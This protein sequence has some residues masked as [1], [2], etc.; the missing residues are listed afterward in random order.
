MGVSDPQ[1]LWSCPLQERRDEAERKKAEAAE[2]KKERQEMEQQEQESLKSGNTGNKVTR[3]QVRTEE[4]VFNK[5]TQSRTSFPD[6]PHSGG[7]Q[8][9]AA[10]V[11]KPTQFGS[12]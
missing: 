2:K 8:T 7:V 6:P 1:R 11:R 10:K 9:S 3:D 4:I 5:E 12:S